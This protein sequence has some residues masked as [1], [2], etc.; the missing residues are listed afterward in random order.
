MV[1]VPDFRELTEALM[2]EPIMRLFRDP[3]LEG[4]ADWEALQ[5]TG[6]MAM[7]FVS[8]VIGMSVGEVLSLF[9]GQAT[10]SVFLEEDVRGFFGGSVHL[11]IDAGDQAEGLSK[12]LGIVLEAM[13]EAGEVGEAEIM[14]R[15]FHTL[16]VSGL[17]QEQRAYFGQVGQM[18]ILS[19]REEAVEAT[20]A[21][22]DGDSS[23]SL[24]SH[25]SFSRIHSERLSKSQL[26]GWLDFSK[27]YRMIQKGIDAAGGPPM[28]MGVL[29]NL[30][31]GGVGDIVMHLTMEGEQGTIME[32]TASVPEADRVGMFEW[33][34]WSGE[35][36]LPPEFVPS[37]VQNF[38][39]MRLDLSQTFRNIKAWIAQME[40]VATAMG[41]N[42]SMRD[43][44]GDN[45]LNTLLDLLGDDIMSVTLPPRGTGFE[46]LE[47]SPVLL[48]V[49]C[50]Q[51]GVALGTLHSLIAPYAQTVGIDINRST[52]EGRVVYSFETQGLDAVQGLAADMDL[53]L[54]ADDDYLLVALEKRI[55]SE[56]LSGSLGSS[57]GALRDLP[58][59]GLA[60]EKLG[61]E[62]M[63]AFGY[64]D[65]DGITGILWEEVRQNPDFLRDALGIIP[66][67]DPMAQVMVESFIS[68]ID[69]SKLPPF[70]VVAKYFPFSVT[71]A[72]RDA[73]FLDF[74]VY[75]PFPPELAQ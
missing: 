36:A 68:M 46:V 57:D 9:Q 30:G 11:L 35:D 51:P 6:Q 25:P 24:A 5:G 54:S 23:R 15:K 74:S 4:F 12:L 75:T 50:S 2:D 59:L 70:E 58:E 39:R 72:S 52:V 64:A 7:R 38:G 60:V 67:L 16:A 10:L 29:E 61:S 21:G 19:M 26:Y 28:L 14:G 31:L 62:S 18:L 41:L 45:R 13:E 20:L 22:L 71:S 66:D 48:L 44:F 40:P 73:D 17:G 56:Y 63:V 69:F 34:A 53:N 1:T 65:A 47:E 32:F 3:A 33:L 55:M 43:P 42:L 49:K 8:E 37:S 27:A